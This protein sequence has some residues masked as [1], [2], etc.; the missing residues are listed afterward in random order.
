MG[1]FLH[2]LINMW[3]LLKKLVETIEKCEKHGTYNRGP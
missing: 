3:K 2:L 1:E